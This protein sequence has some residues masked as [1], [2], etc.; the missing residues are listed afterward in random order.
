MQ[1]TI[2]LTNQDFLLL[3]AGEGS[4]LIDLDPVVTP[5]GFPFV[6]ARTFKG[7]FKESLMEVLEI[8]GRREETSRISNL[9]FG[10]AGVSIPSR[11]RFSNLYL[12]GWEDMQAALPRYQDQF[13]HALQS[14]RIT[15]YY[16]WEVAQTAVDRETGIAQNRSLRNFRV[17]KPDQTFTGSITVLDEAGLKAEIADYADLLQKAGQQLR[18][19]GMHRNRGW[20]RIKV[21][22]EPNGN[23]E[24]VK[25]KE[26]SRWSQDGQPSNA[27]EITL[28]TTSAAVLSAITGDQNTV[29]SDHYVRGGRIRGILAEQ[30]IKAMKLGKS[31]H[32]NEL[33][34]QAILSERLQYRPAYPDQS[35]PLPLNIHYVK[36]QPKTDWV[37]V[38]AS[39]GKNTRTV[40]GL[41]TVENRGHRKVR[42]G[43]TARFHNSRPNRSAGK[44]MENDAEGGIFYYEGLQAR[45]TFTTTLVGDP[46][47]LKMLWESLP[48][49]WNTRIGKSKATQY[50]GVEVVVKP[51][52]S[53]PPPHFTGQDKVLLTFRS[54]VVL[55]NALGHPVADLETLKSYLKKGGVQVA[56]TQAA[57]QT[58]LAE[59]WHGQ[60]QCRTGQV[61][62]FKEGSVF[63]VE[64]VGD[65]NESWNQA[66]Q[67]WVSQGLGEMKN[68][69][70]GWVMVEPFS[71]LNIRSVSEQ[72]T[73]EVEADTVK[74]QVLPESE[75]LKPILN[76]YQQER[77][78][79][80]VRLKAL[81][82]IEGRN[83]I[84][85]H[86][87]GRLEQKLDE[88]FDGKIF[89]L[90][91]V[92]LYRKWVEGL[93]DK[94]AGRELER[95][96]L[97]EPLM[98][99]FV[100]LDQKPAGKP[101]KEAI[102][103][104]PD[105]PAV[106][107]AV[108]GWRTAFRT[109]RNMNKSNKKNNGSKAE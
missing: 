92:N 84:P 36:G 32:E 91:K 9:L 13:P 93:K 43:I 12:E 47:V 16:T 40:G 75:I 26:K 76:A 39:L 83:L 27:L 5:E 24:P 78:L 42:P 18:Y 21:Q 46:T 104:F 48:S 51:I 30:L 22:L 79:N 41:W 11:L 77:A 6:P 86:L 14:Q 4:A 33:F 71:E 80:Q 7:L 56:I 54:P 37:D 53:P 29:S 64:A 107:Q 58:Y 49:R 96:R 67:S 1:F 105:H 61:P 106:R 59:S 109:I 55:H 85:N 34:Q 95:R 101:R 103:P 31:A 88:V 38:F 70:F 94:S 98:D 15:A 10:Q 74:K 73:S 17:V 87:L 81:R 20:G 66:L 8:E 23:P 2:S 52:H 44:S 90:Q 25:E 82:S 19:A 57:A 45:Q 69:G 97:Y 65:A 35:L 63:L 102:S 60:W 99:F 68:Q 50:G 72:E 28:T 3:G 62:A 100:H 108:A 89:N